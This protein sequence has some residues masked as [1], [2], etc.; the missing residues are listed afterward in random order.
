MISLDERKEHTH[1]ITNYIEKKISMISNNKYINGYILV[2]I[3]WILTLIPLVYLFIGNINNIYYF[4]CFI[5]TM[6]FIFHF[7]FKGCIITRVERTIWKEKKWWGPWLFLFT[8]LEKLGID[9]NDELA[10]TIFILW[11]S[12]IILTVFLRLFFYS[13]HR[14]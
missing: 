13:R 3:H 14:N 8:P 11:G 12:S 5:W 1:I 7:Y 4:C 9:M 10:N 2:L 6:I